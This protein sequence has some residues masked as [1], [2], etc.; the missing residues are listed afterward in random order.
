M[1]LDKFQIAV[2]LGIYL[3]DEY[4]ADDQFYHRVGFRYFV[5]KNFYLN[6]TLKSHWAKADYFE[7]GLGIRF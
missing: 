5:N 3:K 7:Y 2:G 4:N 1:T 6:L